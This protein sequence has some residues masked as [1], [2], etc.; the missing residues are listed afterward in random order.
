MLLKR[1]NEVS[2]LSDGAVMDTPLLPLVQ[3]HCGEP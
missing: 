2:V 1:L 3:A